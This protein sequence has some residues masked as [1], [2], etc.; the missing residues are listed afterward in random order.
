MLIFPQ[1]FGFSN[2][3][4]LYNAGHGIIGIVICSYLALN[5]TG[6]T[7]YTSFSGVRKEVKLAAIPMITAV[8]L[9]VLLIAVSK[10]L[11]F[12]KGI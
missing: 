9:A 3:N 12:V 4:L 11:L 5:F 7:T 6:S 1:S 10:V 2:A 8:V